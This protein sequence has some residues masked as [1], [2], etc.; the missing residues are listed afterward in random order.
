MFSFNASIF[1]LRI[2]DT[3]QEIGCFEI[4]KVYE[5]SVAKTLVLQSDYLA[6]KLQVSLLHHINT[7]LK[8]EWLKIFTIYFKNTCHVSL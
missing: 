3:M 5:T 6:V 4:L 2:S 8:L 7:P 1:A